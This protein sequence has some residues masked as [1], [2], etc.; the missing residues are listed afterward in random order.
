MLIADLIA[1]RCF[2]EMARAKKRDVAISPEAIAERIQRDVQDLSRKH[3]RR[4][5]M[6]L[7]DASLLKKDQSEAMPISDNS[8]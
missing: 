5:H 3:G 8:P 6:A 7:V 2:F 4:V 1:E